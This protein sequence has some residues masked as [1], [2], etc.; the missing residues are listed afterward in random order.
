MTIAD[1]L[2]LLI[3]PFGVAV[4][5]LFLLYAKYQGYWY[6]RGEVREIKARLTSV[7]AERDQMLSEALTARGASIEIMNLVRW[8]L[9]RPETEQAEL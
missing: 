3:G 4:L 2:Q 6:T 9:K 1:F 5:A 8:R 7:E